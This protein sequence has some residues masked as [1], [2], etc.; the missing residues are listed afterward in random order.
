MRGD[1]V[2]VAIQG[3]SDKPRPALVIQVDQSGEHTSITVLPV[4]STLVAAPLLRATVQPS[5]ENGLQKAS[6]VMLDKALT[7][8]RDKIGLALGCIEAGA[9]GR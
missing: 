6:Q 3:D 5:I 7:G 8:K 2:A 9:G 4:T 1:F